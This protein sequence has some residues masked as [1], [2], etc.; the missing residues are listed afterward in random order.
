M[1]RGYVFGHMV[2][3]CTQKVHWVISL[4]SWGHLMWAGG[5]VGLIAGLLLHMSSSECLL[6]S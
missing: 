5:G 2:L 4:L 3:H 1:K 6:C